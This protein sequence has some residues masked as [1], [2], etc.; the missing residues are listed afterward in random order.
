[1]GEAGL[2]VALDEADVRTIV[3]VNEYCGESAIRLCPTQLGLAYSERRKRQIVA[4]WVEFLAAGPT[5]ITT[6]YLV[7]RTPKRLFAALAGQPQLTALQVKWGDYD[8]LAAL[9]GMRDLVT[10]RL[11]GASGVTTL[12]PLTSLTNVREL[13]VE[14][15]RGVVDASPI[16]AMVGVENLELGGNWMTPKNVHVPSLSFLREMPQLRHLLLHTLVVDDLDYLP[17]LSL[18]RLEKIRVMAVRG[19]RPTIGELR[20]SLP[21]DA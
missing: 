13:Q 7:T 12:Q 11:R 4:E 6:L 19:M 5:P 2:V 21:W 17:L 18:N 14:G 16:G 15:L 9:S 3:E 8:D 1:M 10:L 20:S